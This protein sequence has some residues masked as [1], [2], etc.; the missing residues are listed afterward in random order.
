ML[1]GFSRERSRLICR[2]CSHVPGQIYYIQYGTV[3]PQSFQISTTP[4]F[5]PVAGVNGGA[6]TQ[7][8]GVP[9]ATSGTQSGVHSYDTYGQSWTDIVLDPGTYYASQ[10][11]PI[12]LGTG[13]QKW[14]L[15]GY[16]ARI[17]TNMDIAA[18]CA[19]DINANTGGSTVKKPGCEVGRRRNNRAKNPP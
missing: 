1:A 18:S 17:A 15:F 11:Q 8:K 19:N 16:G 13:I 4:L 9:V 5:D 3:T 10:N 6:Q 2:S 7:P 14:R 12:G